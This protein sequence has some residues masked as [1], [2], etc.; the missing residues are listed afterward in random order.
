M[1]RSRTSRRFRSNYPASRSEQPR[2]RRFRES[3]DS[4]GEAQSLQLLKKRD[5]VSGRLTAEALEALFVSPDVERR[6][7]TA[8]LETLNARFG[9]P[10]PEAYEWADEQLQ[11]AGGGPPAK[12]RVSRSTR[13]R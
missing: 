8:Y 7:L 13:A 2:A 11:R 9:K 10:S 1:R 3:I 4:V 6:G 12:R 5:R